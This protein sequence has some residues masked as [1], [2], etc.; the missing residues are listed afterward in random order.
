MSKTL[1]IG[2][3]GSGKSWLAGKLSS[4]LSVPAVDLDSIHW[5]PGGHNLRRDK[6]LAVRTVR[7]AAEGEGWVIEGVYG[8]LAREALPRATVLIWLDMDVEECVSN[9]KK[10]GVRGRGDEAS[11]AQ[12]LAWAGEYRLRDNS[13]SF[14]G[15]ERIF[16]KFGGAK[17]RLSSRD[18]I[19]KFLEQ[20]AADQA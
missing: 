11:F 5:E 9:L 7:Q 15:H 17:Y 8:W 16:S 18:E 10:R 3:G 4:S 2:N 13:N 19:A 20:V 12:L 14:A 6:D 1:A